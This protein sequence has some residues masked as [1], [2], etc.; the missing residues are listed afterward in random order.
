MS[1][2]YRL[3]ILTGISAFWGLMTK[4]ERINLI[5]NLIVALSQMQASIADLTLREFGLNTAKE[6][7]YGREDY[8]ITMLREGSDQTLQELAT[9]LNL[10][11]S[12]LPVDGEAESRLWLPGYCRCFLSHTSKHKTIAA[13]LKTA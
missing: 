2:C 10:P 6:W 13:S 3:I 7:E 4:S 1:F 5:Q 12:S 11:N 8:F 9:H